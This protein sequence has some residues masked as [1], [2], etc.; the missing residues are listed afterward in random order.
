MGRWIGLAG[1]GLGCSGGTD[2]DTYPP[3]EPANALSFVVL[4]LFTSQSCSSCPRADDNLNTNAERYRHS[5]QRVFPIA[6][7]VTTWNGLGWVDPYSDPRYSDR[8]LDYVEALDT[9]RFTP[10]MVAQGQQ[11]FNG[12]GASLIYDAKERWLT[13]PGEISV[14]VQVAHGP[15]ALVVTTEVDPVPE[16]ADLQIVLLESDLVD[17]IPSGE[18]AGETLEQDNV[19]RSWV[20][21]AADAPRADLPLPPEVVVD[22]AWVLAFVQDR[23]TMAIV[24]A[25]GAEI[26]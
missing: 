23:D 9:R 13:T 17:A 4:E 26:P 5:D 20:T 3:I 6:W 19:V 18:N 10:Q 16:G 12:Q 14:V 24:G 25:Q 7:H 11:D 1:I 2:P 22:H 8:Q 21:V 15:G